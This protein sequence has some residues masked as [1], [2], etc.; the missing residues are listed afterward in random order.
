VVLGAGPAGLAAAWRAARRG[1]SVVLLEKSTHVGGLAGSF[2]VDGIRVDYGSHRLNPATE[3]EILD[4]LRGLLG[5]DLQTRVRK[6]RLMVAGSWVG[7][8]LRPREVA[9]TLP[10]RLVR[11]AARDAVL[12]PVR[13]ADD[14]YASTTP[15]TGPGPSSSGDFPVTRSPP[16]RP[17]AGRAWTAPGGWPPGRWR[18]GVTAVRRTLSCTRG[19]GSGSS[20]RRWRTLPPRPGRPC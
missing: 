12:S 4:D 17:A 9:S 2:E 8:P 10:P 20:A 13:R 14:S 3:P 11:R 7:Y 19:A 5:D 15:S 1:L 6:D 16:S 18:D